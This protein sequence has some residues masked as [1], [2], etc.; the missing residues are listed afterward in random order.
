MAL[1]RPFYFIDS[2]SQLS[3][4]L[5]RM[6]NINLVL[7]D[8][9]DT[10]TSQGGQY[11]DPVTLHW[12]Q[13]MK[14]SNLKIFLI[15]NNFSGRVKKFADKVDLPFIYLS[16]KPLPIGFALALLKTHTKRKN[17][18]I[19][20][21]QIFTDVLGANL[22]GVKSALVEPNG[23]SKTYFMKFKR[24]IEAPIKSKLIKNKF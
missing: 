24:L 4:E 15:S 21:D 19:V 22:L 16:C 3:P 2:L 18:L 10:L 13:S 8:I 14:A 1:F 7:L 20:G 17:A 6:Q 23:K 12:L 9:D 11:I 5:L